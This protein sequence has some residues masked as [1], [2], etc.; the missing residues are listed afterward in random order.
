[1]ETTYENYTTKEGI[2]VV[3][4]RWDYEIFDRYMAVFAVND[5]T[6][7]LTAYASSEKS[8]AAAK[9]ILLDALEGFELN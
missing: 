1:M 5:I 8:D 3:I 4:L 2:P 9:Q 7:Q 6:Y